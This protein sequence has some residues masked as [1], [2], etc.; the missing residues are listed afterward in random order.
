M[1]QCW[2]DVACAIGIARWGVAR[3]QVA[4]AE[5][6]IGVR[7]STSYLGL[8]KVR[9]FI[10]V[11]AGLRSHSTEKFHGEVSGRALFIYG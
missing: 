7:R 3:E 4:Y 6:Y 8:V 1:T 9:S 2:A 11:S 10:A 5:G